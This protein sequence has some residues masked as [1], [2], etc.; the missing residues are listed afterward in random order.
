M[1]FLECYHGVISLNHM[2]NGNIKIQDKNIEL[3]GGKGYIEKDFGTSFPEKYIWIQSNDFKCDKVS[4]MCSIAKIPFLHTSFSGLIAI[5]YVHGKEYRFATYNFSK[6][7]KICK[8]QSGVLIVIQNKKYKLVIKALYK[9]G[10]I[11]KAPIKGGMNRLI[12]ECIN[13]RVKV[14]L[15]NK[16]SRLIYKGIGDNC[17]IEIV[18]D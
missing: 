4:L 13:G 15:Y 1:P 12:K 10:D 16:R 11:L 5:L 3:N 9:D 17:G 8:S 18:L 7:K 6:I 2:T 14:L